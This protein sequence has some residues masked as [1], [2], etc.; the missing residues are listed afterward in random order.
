MCTIVVRHTD[1]TL[2]AHVDLD[3]DLLPETGDSVT[4]FGSPI[5]VDYGSTIEV[6]RKARLVRGSQLDK[7]VTGLLAMFELTELYEVSFS[8]GMMK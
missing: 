2:E 3:D 5:Q 4:V 8:P 7:A 6:R 1:E